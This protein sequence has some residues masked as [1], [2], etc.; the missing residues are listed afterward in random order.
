MG[1]TCI[2]LLM[3]CT[4]KFYK[5]NCQIFLGGDV[6]T[7]FCRFKFQFFSTVCTNVATN[8]ADLIM[9][10]N[11]FG[12][13]RMIHCVHQDDA[14]KRSNPIGLENDAG[15]ISTIQCVSDLGTSAIHPCIHSNTSTN[16]VSQPQLWSPVKVNTQFLL[17]IH[18]K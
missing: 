14:P 16:C 7:M 3:E 11:A 12:L 5:F 13:E 18:P 15:L 1:C 4:N 2:L 6:P 17:F 8:V 9:L 10:E